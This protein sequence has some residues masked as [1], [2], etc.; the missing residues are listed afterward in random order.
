MGIN[1]ELLIDHAWGWE[2]V[3][4]EQIKDY[5]PSTT[6][7]SSGQVLMRPYEYEE[8]RLIVP[9]MMELLA[10]DLVRKGL[11]SK[12]VVLTIGYDRESLK[13]SVPGKG[14]K[15]TIY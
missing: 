13:A 11:V 6:S 4:M 3:G 5:R 1:A 8:G 9:E 15:D 12:Q 10:L 2:P 14:I 7:I